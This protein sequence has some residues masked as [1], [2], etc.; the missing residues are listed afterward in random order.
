MEE[1]DGERYEETGFKVRC[2]LVYNMHN[3]L[4][5]NLTFRYELI[6]YKLSPLKRNASTSTYRSIFVHVALDQV[7]VFAVFFMVLLDGGHVCPGF[8]G[9]R[10]WEGVFPDKVWAVGS[11][12]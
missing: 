10:G 3:N 12:N 6:I 11:R 8:S 2:L 7:V 4:P 9:R 5:R 1:K